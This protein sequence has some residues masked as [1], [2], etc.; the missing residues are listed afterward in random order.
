M[1]YTSACT[2]LCLCLTLL[3]LSRVV[4]GRAHFRDA[5]VAVQAWGR[6][7]DEVPW[8]QCSREGLHPGK[9]AA[10]VFPLN[11]DNNRFKVDTHRRDKRQE[12]VG[13]RDSVS[14]ASPDAGR[15]GGRGQEERKADCQSLRGEEGE[16][17]A[18]NTHGAGAGAGAADALLSPWAASRT[19][20]WLPGCSERPRT[21]GTF[22]CTVRHD[23]ASGGNSTAAATTTRQAYDSR[24]ICTYHMHLNN[25]LSAQQVLGQR[26]SST[27]HG[28]QNQ[29]QNQ[30]AT[31]KVSESEK[32]RQ[33]FTKEPIVV[34]W[35]QQVDATTRDQTKQTE[36]PNQI[37]QPPHTTS[38]PT[39]HSASYKHIPLQERH[40]V[41][42]F[43]KHLPPSA[44]PVRAESP[45]P[46]C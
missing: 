15:S 1:L 37:L 40:A 46:E 3:L 29:N 41:M 19:R 12:L 4:L 30:G 2:Y 45:P 39:R 34:R 28:N 8:L 7:S 24:P 31:T 32:G 27:P 44:S 5:H 23:T 42:V 11:P 36:P 14:S 26:T 22:S 6:A 25:A 16:H 10:H 21:S 18:W 17:G 43:P 35:L 9:H 13:R 33:R 20:S 38:R